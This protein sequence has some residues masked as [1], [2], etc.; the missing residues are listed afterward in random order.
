MGDQERKGEEKYKLKKYMQVIK[1][2]ADIKKIKRGH[3]EQLTLVNLKNYIKWT[4]LFKEITQWY[5]KVGWQD[6]LPW[7][8]EC[9]H[10]HCSELPGHNDGK[11]H[12]Y[13]VDFTVGFK[14]SAGN[15][16][17]L[18]ATGEELTPSASCPQLGTLQQRKQRNTSQ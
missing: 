15:R 11:Q 9:F 6:Y 17:L 2:V 18:P 14:F 13:F 10:R 3:F 12:S 1:Q 8:G 4:N 5:A 7:W 16:P